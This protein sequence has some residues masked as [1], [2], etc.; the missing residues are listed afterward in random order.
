M[1][2]SL[3]GLYCTMMQCMSRGPCQAQNVKVNEAQMEK[4]CSVVVHMM[5]RSIPFL[6]SL[7]FEV[8]RSCIGW[9]G[10]AGEEAI[11]WGCFGTFAHSVAG[12]GWVLWECLSNSRRSRI[13]PRCPN[14]VFKE[15]LR[16]RKWKYSCLESYLC[17]L[18]RGELWSSCVLRWQYRTW[19]SCL[20]LPLPSYLLKASGSVQDLRCVMTI[21]SE[22]NYSEY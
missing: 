5:G 15:L 18:Q 22:L 13:S 3:Y 2:R 21:L 17:F 7:V 14:M 12:Q 10:T 11:G 20:H 4:A 6:Y 16:S 19:F 9:W 8:S 1:W